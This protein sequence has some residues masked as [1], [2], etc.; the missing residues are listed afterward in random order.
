MNIAIISEGI[1]D[2]AV[3]EN[4]CCGYFDDPDLTL[5]AL[6]PRRDETDKARSGH[7][8]NWE[9]VFDYCSKPIFKAAFS[10]NDYIIIQ[11]DTDVSEEINF[12]IHKYKNGKE[13]SVDELIIEVKN[14]FISI[15]GIDFYEKYKK[16]ILCAICVHS[17]EC[18]LLPLNTKDPKK[19]SHT[20]NCFDRLKRATGEKVEKSYHVYHSLSRGYI[21]HKT[22]MKYSCKNSSLLYFIEELKKVIVL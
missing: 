16:R 6:Q 12:G 7:F 9:L 18:W 21:K 8:G 13:L 15:I 5:N 4:I 2:Q 22:L 11:I 17:L 10:S 19:Q 1:T 3:I 20:K 14:K